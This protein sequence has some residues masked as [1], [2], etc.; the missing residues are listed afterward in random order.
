MSELR[1]NASEADRPT[2]TASTDR[3]VWVFAIV[4]AAM[5]L[6]VGI[7]HAL[8]VQI[9]GRALKLDA[10]FLAIVIVGVLPLV[11]LLFPRLFDRVKSINGLGLKLE[12]LEKDVARQQRAIDEQQKIL[13]RLTVFSMEGDI[14]DTLENLDNQPNFTFNKNFPLLVRQFQFLFDRDLI[15]RPPDD[16]NEGEEVGSGKLVTPLGKDYIKI[17]RVMHLAEQA[18]LASS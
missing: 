6:L 14:F 16:L 4:V 7:V 17:R 1:E 15:N 8:D 12:L 18:R 3:R 10:T 9:W 5:A 11:A 2:S 13:N